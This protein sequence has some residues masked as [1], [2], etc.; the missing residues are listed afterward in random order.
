MLLLGPLVSRFGSQ[1]IGQMATA[2][3]NQPDLL[4]LNEW[5]AAGQITPVIDRC[6]PLAATAE[7]IRYLETG[8]ARGKVVVTVV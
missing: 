7:A 8:R 1:K 4:K 5:L 3:P 6:Y 2:S